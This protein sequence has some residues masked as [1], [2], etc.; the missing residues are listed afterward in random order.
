ML[1][2]ILMLLDKGKYNG[3]VDRIER[4]S[5]FI[6]VIKYMIVCIYY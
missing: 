6:N 5:S 4:Y 1:V 3:W 2:V